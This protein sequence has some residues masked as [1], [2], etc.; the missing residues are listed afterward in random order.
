[1]KSVLALAAL[2]AGLVWSIG[3]ASAETVPFT[4][5]AFHRAVAAGGP[6]IIQLHADW[7][8]TCAAQAPIIAALLAEP[9]R[10]DVTFFAADFDKETALKKQLKIT[11]Q[12]TFVV[13]K[14]GKEVTR[15]TGQTQREA[16]EATFDKAL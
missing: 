14:G 5:Q 12:S 6:V 13:Y 11:Q 15:S 3:T 8:P 1:M 9:K 4:L 7:C 10:R 16:I 2:L